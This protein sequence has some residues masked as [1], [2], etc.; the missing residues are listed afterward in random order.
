MTGDSPAGPARGRQPAGVTFLRLRLFVISYAPLLLIFA[1]RFNGTALRSA[2]AAVALLGFLD[3]WRVT[4]AVQGK[5]AMELT[6]VAVRDSGGEVAGYLA[7]YLLPFVA[8][9]SPTARDL[10]GYGL[11]FV[12]VAAIFLRSEL[13]HVN[14]TLYLLGWRVVT[15]VLSDR[16]EV[17]LVCRRARAGNEPVRA[18]RLAGLYVEKAGG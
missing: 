16:R 17:Y 6:P 3:G 5:A 4:R 10:V 11:Y 1:V 15:L 7:T 18:V 9:A 8:V 12:V 2:C 13:A 14:P